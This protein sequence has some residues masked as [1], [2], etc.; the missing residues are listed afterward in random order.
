MNRWGIPPHVEEEVLRRDKKCVYCGVAFTQYVRA[1]R[2]RIKIATWEH[3][4]NDVDNKTVANIALCCGACNSSTGTKELAAWLA[5]QYCKE[6]AIT[7]KTV[8]S[9]VK[10]RLKRRRSP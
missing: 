8:A 2:R 3:I 1:S 6:N 4:D 9:V 7:A 5:S 10:N